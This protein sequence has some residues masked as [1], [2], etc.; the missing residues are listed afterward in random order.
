M[1]YFSALIACV[2]V[3]LC[4]I[5][6]A[7]GDSEYSKVLSIGGNGVTI[8]DTESNWF[9]GANYTFSEEDSDYYN[10][11]T[12]HELSAVIGKRIYLN[13]EKARSFVDGVVDVSHH[14][15]DSDYSSYRISAVYGL[16]TF[17]SSVVSI[18]GSVGASIIYADGTS[19]N[20]TRLSVPF[21]RFSLSYYFD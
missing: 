5:S 20:Y 2:G 13:N 1:K 7:E 4:G 9:Y 17:I 21:G 10:S 11:D 19:S 14:F 8:R 3:S 15:S 18:E 16:E 12:S 6:Q